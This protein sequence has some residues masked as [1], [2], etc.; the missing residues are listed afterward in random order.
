MQEV[1]VSSADIYAA[2]MV[3]AKSEGVKK[4]CAPQ[5]CPAELPRALSDGGE[6]P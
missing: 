2:L 5:S 3:D 1:P 6:D 4:E